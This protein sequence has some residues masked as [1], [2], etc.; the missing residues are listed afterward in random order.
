MSSFLSGMDQILAEN[1][2]RLLLGCHGSY[3]EKTC[4]DRTESG[5][6]GVS[7]LFL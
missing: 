6:G 4:S 2:N 5:A 3:I 1:E 7:Y